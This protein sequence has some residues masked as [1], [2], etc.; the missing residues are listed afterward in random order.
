[1]YISETASVHLG[2]P[3]IDLTGSSIFEYIHPS[4]RKGISE[5]LSLSEKDLNELNQSENEG[6]NYSEINRSF[7]MRMKCILPKRNAGLVSG[8]YKAIHC[9]GYLKARLKGTNS[10]EIDACPKDKDNVEDENNQSGQD[11]VNNNQ[12]HLKEESQNI[13]LDMNLSSLG[14]SSP[15]SGSASFSSSASLRSASTLSRSPTSSLSLA[16]CSSKWESY[17]LVA[18]GHSLLPTASTEVKLNRYTFSFRANLDMNLNYIEALATSSL[19]FDQSEMIG[20]SL[21]QFLHIDDLES[22]GESH[23]VLLEKG[24]TVTKYIRFIKKDGGSIWIQ[25]H[26]T[27]VANPRNTPRPQNIIGVCY[28]LGEDNTDG[29]VIYNQLIDGVRSVSSTSKTTDINEKRGA[30]DSKTSAA[31]NE[32]KYPSNSVLKNNHISQNTQAITSF[33]STPPTTKTEQRYLNSVKQTIAKR[34]RKSRITADI[35]IAEAKLSNSSNQ[36]CAKPLSVTDDQSPPAQI[37]TLSNVASA[38]R[39]SCNNTRHEVGPQGY[40]YPC[41]SSEIN[42]IGPSRRISDDNCS[43]FSNLTSAS[44]SS[45]S[46]SSSSF[47]SSL[48]YITS[49]NFSSQNQTRMDLISY[50]G[51]ACRY[52]LNRSELLGHESCSISNEPGIY[53]HDMLNIPLDSPNIVA[54]SSN[55][56]HISSLDQVANDPS[57]SKITWPSQVTLVEGH[58]IDLGQTS[59]Q[60]GDATV[61]SF[62]L[63]SGQPI[64]VGPG[65]L[66]DHPQIDNQMGHRFSRHE[67]TENSHYSEFLY[68]NPNFHHDSGTN[69]YLMPTHD[70]MNEHK[71]TSQPYHETSEYTKN[72]SYI[73]R[74]VPN[75]ATYCYQPLFNA[76]GQTM[77]TF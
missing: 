72:A 44:I 42:S 46:G 70:S 34:T 20:R 29:S 37:T 43:I 66:Q 77:S 11:T 67:F 35:T 71:I 24:Q 74:N 76:N 73:P 36:K 23:R 1:M 59:Y 26:A 33:K 38:T 56:A 13:K 17:A 52:T 22:F 19:G 62:N 58:S 50:E 65:T 21:Y 28:V 5:I 10:I 39:V 61:C 55:R 41:L 18:V 16:S 30:S 9:Y 12:Q 2:L 27:L 47:T 63:I 7:C 68:D 40:I 32:Q 49:P 48:P 57:I 51:N 31:I 6:S 54:R 75:E 15:D 53:D 3:Q 14:S 45:S 25:T 8:G 64:I 4:D 69:G 60:A